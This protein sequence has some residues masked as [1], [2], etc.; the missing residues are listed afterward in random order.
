V[1][2]Q[3]KRLMREGYHGDQCEERNPMGYVPNKGV[4]GTTIFF[5]S[6]GVILL[7]E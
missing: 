7:F 1:G 3:R 2:P 5:N 4:S 6:C